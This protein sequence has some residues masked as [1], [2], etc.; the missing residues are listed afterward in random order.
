MGAFP[1]RIDGFALLAGCAVG[2]GLGLLGAVPPAFRAL[3]LE[4]VE[5]LKSI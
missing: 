5:A 4:I 2:L 3:R 1:L